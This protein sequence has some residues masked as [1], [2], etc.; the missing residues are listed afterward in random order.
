MA[1]RRKR[2]KSL[3]RFLPIVDVALGITMGCLFAATYLALK[4]VAIR[5]GA[6]RSGEKEKERHE[7]TYIRGRS[8]L[9][10]TSVIDAKKTSFLSRDRAGVE[11]SEEEI[12]R[13]ISTEYGNSPRTAEYEDFEAEF[14][15]DVPVF[16]VRGDETE[17]GMVFDLS[18]LGVTRKVVLQ[19]AGAFQRE[20]GR[21]V[22]V[23][24]KMYVGS[25]PVNIP[26]LSRRIFN[27]VYDRFEVSSDLSEAWAD[28]RGLAVEGGLIKLDFDGAAPVAAVPE[29]TPEVETPDTAVS[30]QAISEVQVPSVQETVEEASEELAEPVVEEAAP[31]VDA[32][33]ETADE[34]VDA[35]AAGGE[36]QENT[37]DPMVDGAPVAEVPGEIDAP[38]ESTEEPVTAE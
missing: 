22:F 17:V 19:A 32:A 26:Y 9:V 11:L 27:A 36:A 8:G 20:G 18:V 15:A 14:R 30:E 4:P 37:G 5:D 21:F 24:E 1:N 10:R 12:N 38:V 29:S 16:K 3:K 28:V 2:K 7:V 31:A 23:P 34:T 33:A 6:E 25:C 13:W 35:V